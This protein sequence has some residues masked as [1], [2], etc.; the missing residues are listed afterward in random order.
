[1]N[2]MS[3]EEDYYC[4]NITALTLWFTGWRCEGD[5]FHQ[6]VI[7]CQKFGDTPKSASEYLCVSM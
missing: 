6:E 2:T 5:Q 7:F 1:M 3:Q 4:S